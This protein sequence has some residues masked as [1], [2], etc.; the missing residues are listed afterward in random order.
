MCK[1]I[2]DILFPLN[3]LGK[4]RVCVAY[5]VV[6]STAED[7]TLNVVWSG[8]RM[9][10][11][12]TQIAVVPPPAKTLPKRKM[13][14]NGDSEEFVIYARQ[15]PQRIRLAEDTVY[16]NCT[17]VTKLTVNGEQLI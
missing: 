1:F 5:K 13:H 14:T 16:F 4:K 15:T 2:K 10:V 9:E 12:Y 7:Y 17:N 3:L 8:E 6:G 11:T